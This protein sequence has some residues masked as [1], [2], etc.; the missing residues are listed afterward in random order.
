MATVTPPSSTVQTVI[1]FFAE[2][3]GRLFSKTPAFF[4]VI[5]VISTLLSIVTGLPTVL[6]SLGIPL[7]AS[8][9]GLENTVLSI[10]GLVGLFISSLPVTTSTATSGTA[11]ASSAALP[12]T[13][14]REVTT[15]TVTIK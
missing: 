13:A 14:T 7:P 8:I 9:T 10:A 12:F 15:P 5:Q 1:A 2:L 4:K 3:V 6:T 11:V